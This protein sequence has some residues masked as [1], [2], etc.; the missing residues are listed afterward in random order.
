MPYQSIFTPN[1]QRNFSGDF[2]PGQYAKVN[3][4]IA[5]NSQS[6]DN[7]LLSSPAPAKGNTL[8]SKLSRAAQVVGKDTVSATKAVGRPVKDVVTGKG[9]KA[10]HDTAQLTSDL[11]GGVANDITN[12][13]VKQ[14]KYLAQPSATSQERRQIIGNQTKAEQ[15]IR[16]GKVNKPTQTLIKKGGQS[17]Q[18]TVQ[19]QK[20]IA[21]G[22][23]DKK[24]QQ[25]ITKDRQAKAN[26]DKKAAGAA[27][28]VASLSPM[29]EAARAASVG[30]D[31]AVE[32]TKSATAGAIGNEGAALETH[33]NASGKELGKAGVEG[34]VGGAVLP[35]AGKLFGLGAKVVLD[36]IKASHAAENGMK[37]VMTPEQADK[38]AA[39]VHTKITPAD[40]SAGAEQVG[41]KTPTHA[42]IKQQSETYKIGVRTPTHAGIKEQSSTYKIGVRT[43]Q[44]MTD[45]QYSKEFGSLSSAYDKEM[46]SVAGKPD[47][48]QKALAGHIDNK[49]QVLIND[50]NERYKNGYMSESSAP[51][52]IASETTSTKKVLGKAPATKRIASQTSKAEK[53]TGGAPEAGV[54]VPRSSKYNLS[55]AP[56]IT[57]AEATDKLQ[58]AGYTPDETKTILQDAL[59]EKPLSMP[60]TKPKVGLNDESV[61]KSAENLD[62]S[63]GEV[64]ES[65]NLRPLEAT[66]ESEKGVSKLGSSVQEGAI[67]DKLIGK[68]DAESLPTY[69]KANLKEQAQFTSELIK[70]DP[71]RAINIALGKE[72]APAHILPQMVYNGVEEYARHIGGDDGGKL[73]LDLSKSKQVT[74]LT[75]MAQN[76]RAAAERDPHSPTNMINDVAVARANKVKGGEQAVTTAIKADAKAVR[77]ATPKIS[78]DDWS[79][80]V[81]GLRC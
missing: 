24:V 15:A 69:N 44:S 12:Q 11:T 78:K 9:G 53:P 3:A 13:T 30:K 8:F 67:H 79:A 32:V 50:L 23:P 18:G 54:N 81:D 16:S 58:S 77:A 33:P 62:K 14:A 34:F 38:A 63:N 80:F 19:T 37:D 72:E 43:K 71:Q 74:N 39:A 73:L 7:S 51:K 68:T 47:A 52:K 10:V 36:K 35:V 45:E 66:P 2:K 22:A 29:G 56:R 26:L 60:G 6:Q 46:K 31:L 49:Y 40:E 27:L 76:V 25:Q 65:S 28:S 42:G 4:N 64:Q 48:T 75:T 61:Q 17:A 21:T 41:V 1:S 70:S 5:K 55:G 59:P 57:P 20:L